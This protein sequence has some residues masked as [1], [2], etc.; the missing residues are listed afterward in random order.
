G[1]GLH[2]PAL[3]NDQSATL[4]KVTEGVEVSTG[5]HRADLLIV[6]AGMG[7]IAAAMAALDRGLSVTMTEEYRW[8]GGQLTVQG[9]PLDEHPWIEEIGAP[10]S[11]RHLRT[12]LREHFRQSNRLT[13]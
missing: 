5:N 7:G 12:R 3:Q 9:T 11:Y 10:A 13:S 6:G 1:S 4:S 8:I 2:L